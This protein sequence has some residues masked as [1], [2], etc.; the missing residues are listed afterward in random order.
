MKRT[1]VGRAIVKP[2]KP[3]PPGNRGRRAEIGLTA[4]LAASASAPIQG[5]SY[6]AET[7]TVVSV[8][9]R[10]KRGKRGNCGAEQRFRSRGRD[11]GAAGDKRRRSTDLKTVSRPRLPSCD[12][13]IR[14]YSSGPAY[15]TKRLRRV[16]WATAPMWWPSTLTRWTYSR[17]GLP[18]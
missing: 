3:R 6:S 13:C 12:R 11:Y 14:S 5:T 16:A 17:P 1:G 15:V 4:A 8:K 18:E 7:Q 9:W 10:T 2:V